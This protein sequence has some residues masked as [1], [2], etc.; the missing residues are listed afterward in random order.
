MNNE[1]IIYR[2]SSK[3][4]SVPGSEYKSDGTWSAT[5]IENGR[6]VVN[7]DSDKVYYRQ[8]SG[9]TEIMTNSNV[10]DYWNL[11]GDTTYSG[12]ILININVS[13]YTHGVLTN[14]IYYSGSTITSIDS[15]YNGI[16]KTLR[17]NY[18]NGK[19]NNW[20]YD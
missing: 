10:V 19:I 4:P 9:I 8:N 12:N 2:Q 7:V 1:N 15:I 11:S 20:T 18:N 6:M 5:D 3:I 14:N 17:L 16:T 13:G